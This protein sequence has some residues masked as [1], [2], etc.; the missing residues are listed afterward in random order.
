LSKL[1][2]KKSSK[3]RSL[4]VTL[5][6]SFLALSGIVLLIASSLDIY[7]NF[8]S[9]QNLVIA[10]QRLIAQEA[11]NSVKGFIQKKFEILQTAN[12]IGDLA[13]SSHEQQKLV[14]DKL[15]GLEPAFRQL[16]LLNAQDRELQRVA[17]V[18]KLALSQSIETF[19]IE[20]FSHAS[21]GEKYVSPVYI[22][23]VTSEPLMIMAV[24]ITDVFGVFHGILTAEV[25]LKF[26]WDLVDSIKIGKRGVAY[27]VDKQGNLIAFG[28]ISRVLRGEKLF[29]L[30][31]VSK[32]VEGDES[33]HKDHANI[34][35]GIRGNRVVCNHAHLIS[36]DT[37]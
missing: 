28:D 19:E 2:T 6:I 14:L 20:L 16:I 35:N 21:K 25:N 12:S 15:L 3:V 4:T 34:S 36:P 26:M 22:D 31:E 7:F 11:A 9:Q 5:A 29:H 18:S 30:E 1:E 10:Q 33:I 8:R 37:L 32:F 13:I 27:V 23:N 24:P 17:R